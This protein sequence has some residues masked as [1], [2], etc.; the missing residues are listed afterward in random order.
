MPY[1]SRKFPDREG[2]Y[3]T[4]E[5]ECL[6]I[7]WV[8]GALRYYLLGFALTLYSDHAMNSWMQNSFL[9]LNKDKTEIFVFGN[10]EGRLRLSAYLESESLQ[11]TNN[12]KILCVILDS[13]VSFVIILKPQLKQHSGT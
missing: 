9:Q 10:K 11:K 2:R 13:D 8:V 3:S 6:A 4:V 1:L 7:R 5:K 12:V